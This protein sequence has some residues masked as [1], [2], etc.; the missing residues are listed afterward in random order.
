[1]IL[2][3][4]NNW[5]ELQ[6]HVAKIFRDIGFD[7]MIEKHITTARGHV[8]IDVYA[9]DNIFAGFGALSAGF[10]FLPFFGLLLTT[11]L[12]SFI[13]LAV[14]YLFYKRQNES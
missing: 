4:P 13:N 12:A 10:I 11:I 7:T 6:N 5:R 8:V 3:N 1:M 9:V 2:S 14:G